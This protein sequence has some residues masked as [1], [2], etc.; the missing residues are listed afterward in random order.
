MKV[1]VVDTEGDSLTPT[2]FHVISYQLEGRKGVKS[3]TDYDTMRK[4]LTQED[5]AFVMHNGMLWD[6]PELERVL[7]IKIKAKLIDTLFL[8]W[9]CFPARVLH[10][11]DSFGEEA[12]IPKPKVTDWE[13][14][15]IEV[16]VNRCSEDVK[17]NMYVWNKVKSFLSRLYNVHED[18]V[19][20]LPIVKYLMFK[21][22]C[23]LEQQRSKW[24]LDIPLVETTLETLYKARTEKVEGLARVMPKVAKTALREPPAKPYKK[25]G[26][27]SVQ[28]VKWQS[29][30]RSKGLPPDHTEPVEVVVKEE[31]PNPGSTSQV[32]DWLYSLGWDPITFKYDKNDDGTDRLIPQIRKDDGG[33]KVLCPSVVELIEK[34]PAIEL[35]DGLTV[36]SHRISILEGF[37]ENVDEEGFVQAKIQGLT[38]TLRFK[39]KVCVNLPGIDKPWGKEIRGALIA[40]EGYELM[41]SDIMS[42]EDMTKRHYIYPY[43]PDYV[44][45]MDNPD[46][47][48]PLDLAIQAGR[49]TKEDAVRHV[50]KE[51]DFGAIRKTFKPVNYGA[52]YGIGVPKL[53]REMRVPQYEAKVLLDT[54]WQRNWSIRKLAEDQVVKKIQGQMWLLNP[55]SGFWYSLR[56][57]KDRFST[58]N[59]GT[60]V[61][62]FDTWLR[63][64]RSKRKQMTAQF[65]DEGVWEIKKGFR[66]KG[67]S[68]LRWAMKKTN[69]ELNLNVTIDIDVQFG[70]SYGQIH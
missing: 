21:A 48:A 3:I 49:I 4:F 17:I 68:L 36:I 30:L 23:A 19:I 20:T 60:G 5:C 65:H 66:D 44:K 38:N 59:Q 7:G 51:A 11:L 54:Y 40:R 67:E 39:H 70:D 35:L 28:G 43:D 25:D 18:T 2:K 41:G 1:F 22:D 26:T 69:E 55:V 31:D 52:V 12:G 37:L 6:K 53:A 13:D 46:Y 56:Y 42:L 15:P 61:F 58:L 16:Y 50:R 9:Y 24:K 62:V 8:S 27:L 32:K 10:G 34:E 29:L 57:D 33:V 47:D 45:E 64:V 63:Y 14:Q